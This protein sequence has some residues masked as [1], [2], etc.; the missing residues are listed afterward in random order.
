MG[1]PGA[2]GPAGPGGAPGPQGPPGPTGSG[3][4]TEELGS[5]AGFTP[6]TYTGSISGGRPGAH[7]TCAAAFPGSHLCHAAEYIQS[8]SATAVPASG[9]WV[10][11]S[12][13][14]GSSTSNIGMPGSGRTVY[15]S[16]CNSWTDGTTGRSAYWVNAGGSIDSTGD[17]SASRSLACCNTPVKVHF[18]GFTSATTNGNGGGRPKMHGACASEFAG[19]HM[20][21]ASE[22][23]RAASGTLVPMSGGWLDPST[24][25]GTS[26][27]NIG[28]PTSGRTVYGSTCNSWTDGTTGRSAYWVNTSGSIDSTGDCSATRSIAC[29]I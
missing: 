25:N 20:C 1:P 27:S 29:C 5:F 17:C 24:A 19:S 26:T 28:M 6:S 14:D 13:A 4:Y 3:A 22:Y 12:T 8:N 18:A 11:P 10:D 23:I 15:G 16:T 2:T 7:A 9:G 21:H